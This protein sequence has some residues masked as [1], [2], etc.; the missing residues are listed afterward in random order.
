MI[1]KM[2]RY[3]KAAIDYAKQFKNWDH[4]CIAKDA[5]I[6][7]F[8]AGYTS[9]TQAT[10]SGEFTDDFE[11]VEVELKDGAHQLTNHATKNETM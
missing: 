6:S 3:E 4:K 1:A 2:K 11:D 10:I 9:A 5:Y 7:A 8:V